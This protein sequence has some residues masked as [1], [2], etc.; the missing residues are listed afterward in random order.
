MNWEALGAIAEIVGVIGVL[1]SLFY[2]ALQ[3]RQNTH[4]LSA[5]L[6]PHRLSAF[7]RIIESGNPIRE[8]FILNPEIVE[9]YD[10]GNRAYGA[11]QGLIA[12]VTKC[13]SETYFLPFKVHLSGSYQCL[14]TRQ[15]QRAP[16]NLLT[17]Y[18]IMKGFG[19]F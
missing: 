15:G 11:M 16:L 19:C 17:R 14:I 9:L 8:L 1:I 13:W 2:L 10:T 18:S 4:Q 3:I 12:S 5:S 7:E 6:E